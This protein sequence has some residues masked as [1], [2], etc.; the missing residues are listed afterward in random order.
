[1]DHQFLQRDLEEPGL[2]AEVADFHAAAR[3]VLQAGDDLALQH[4]LE[5]R[6]AHDD[7]GGERQHQQV[8]HQVERDANRFGDFPARMQ[9]SFKTKQIETR[10]SKFGSTQ[11][12]NSSFW[13]LEPVLTPR[14]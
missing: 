14:T 9:P 12:S 2:K 3:E 13:H 11:I 10:N 6:A 5:P 1:M 4:M 7:Q 8:F